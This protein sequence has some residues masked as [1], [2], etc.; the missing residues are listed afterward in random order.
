MKDPLPHA[1]VLARLG[2]S[3]IHGIGVFAGQDIAAETLVFVNERQPIRWVDKA[4][5]AASSPTPFEQGLYDDFAIRRVE[6]LGTPESF[7]VI[8]VGW[9]V[10][11]PAAGSEPNLRLGPDITFVA[12]RAI[13][14]GEELTITYADFSWPD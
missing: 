9:Y 12:A 5:V 8:P 1:G 3:T 11:E 4:K 10:N 2:V 7:D 6:Q 13:K 14:S